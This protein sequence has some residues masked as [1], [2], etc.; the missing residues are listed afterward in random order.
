MLDYTKQNDTT[1]VTTE[2][3]KNMKFN[4]YLAYSIF[5]QHDIKNWWNVS[6]NGSAAYIQY[7]GDVNGAVFNTKSIY[8]NASLTNTL[9]VHK[10]TKFEIIG[11]YRGPKNNGL[12]QIKSRWMVSFALKQTFFKGKLDGSIGLNDIFYTFVAHTYVNFANQNW[13]YYQTIDTRRIVLSLNYNF[14]KLKIKE[15]EIS[16]NEQEKARLN[17]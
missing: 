13:N 16:S 6:A 3:V 14:G 4:N 8:Y 11:I 2:T 1:K 5:M 12:V 17:H 15:R 10:N 9:I 7:V